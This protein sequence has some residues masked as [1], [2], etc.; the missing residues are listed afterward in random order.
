MSVWYVHWNICSGFP[1]TERGKTG[2][3]ILT[4]EIN[5]EMNYS[6]GK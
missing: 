4:S 1:H 3:K 5:Y 2:V 6:Q